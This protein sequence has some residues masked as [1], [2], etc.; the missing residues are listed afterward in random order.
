[1]LPESDPWPGSRKQHQSSS[2][3][4]EQGVLTD[5]PAVRNALLR[6]VITLEDNFHDRKDLL[7]EAL[8]YVRSS[9][10]QHPGQRLSWYLQGVRFYL[11]HFRTSGRSLDS[12]KHRGEQASFPEDCDEWD[13]WRDGLELDE[14]IMSEINAHDIFFL[15]A[16]RLEP[17]DQLILRGMFEGLRISEIADALHVPRGFVDRHRLRIAKLAVKLGINPLPAV[18]LRRGC[19]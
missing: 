16:D 3:E 2:V 15:L 19:S 10:R 7:Q 14:G 18:P 4:Q 5:K 1:L 11:H 17:T 12:P 13:N 6:M 8:V 9:E